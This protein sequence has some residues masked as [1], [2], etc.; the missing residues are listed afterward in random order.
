MNGAQAPREV[1]STHSAY[2]VT[3]RRRGRPETLRKR[4]ARNL[5]RVG[6]RHVLQQVERDAVR[7]VLEAA[8]AEAVARDVGARGRGSAARSAVHRCAGVF[9]ANVDRFARRVADRVVR[10]GRELVL[11][12]VL[13]PGVAAALGRHLEAEAR[14]GDHVDPGRR[15]AC[16]LLEDRRRIRARPR[17]SRPGR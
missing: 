10:P 14:V 11:A 4:Q 12:A 9:I 13:R 3:D 7:L 15:R 2:A 17:R 6:Q 1:P 8:V 5:D 16:A